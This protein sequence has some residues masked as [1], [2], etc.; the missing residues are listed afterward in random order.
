[1]SNVTIVEGSLFEAETKYIAHQCNCLTLR[2]GHLARAMFQE[3]PFADI[4]KSRTRVNDWTQSRDKPG[5]IIIRGNGDDERY[6]IN[7]IAQVF[8]G[9][10]RYPQSRADGWEARREYFQL[11]LSH[12]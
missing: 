4:Y 2:G 3:F 8:P 5:S 7:M 12:E 11:C 9:K 1:M 10:A 6:V